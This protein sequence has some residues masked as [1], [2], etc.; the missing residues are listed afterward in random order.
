MRTEL[1]P[2]QI[3]FHRENGYLVI[4][5]FLT[6]DELAE[7]RDAIDEAVAARESKPIQAPR[8]E[9]PSS[10]T[11][12]IVNT[13]LQVI[14][15]WKDSER[16]RS[17]VL[18]E[19]IGR[20]AAELEGVE[21]YRMWHDQAL[22]KRPWDNA[23]TFHF[24]VPY[25]SFDSRHAVTIWVAL[26]DATLVNGCLY[27]LPGTHKLTRFEPA[28][29]LPNMKTVFEDYPEFAE[30]EAVPQPM[31]AGS[32]AIQN[33]MIVHGAATN[34]T[35]RQRRAM[36]FN[37]MPIGSTFNGNQNVLSTEQVAALKIGEELC[38]ERQNPLIFAAN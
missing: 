14:N 37:L 33:S 29:I 36:T 25:W 19:R 27:Y 30:I 1:T 21:G 31:R 24:D 2:N 9:D 18:D 5:D 8:P 34:M 26:D 35:P 28:Y 15:I 20:M 7:W 23:T 16:V 17:L 11:D 22:I 10:K 6:P 13:F 4:E 3:A 38:D 12:Y 32:C